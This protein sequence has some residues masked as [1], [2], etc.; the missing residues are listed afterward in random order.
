M[1]KPTYYL[2]KNNFTSQEEFQAAKEKYRKLG[3]RV[4]AYIDGPTDKNIHNGL[5]NIIKNHYDSFTY[6]E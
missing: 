1:S 3:F 6:K 2:W 4:V 5:K